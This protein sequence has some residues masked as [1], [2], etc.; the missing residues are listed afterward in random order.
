MQCFDFEHINL[1][2][3]KCIVESRKECDT[4]VQIGKYK[5]RVPVIPANM[6]CVINEE[7]AEK[8]AKNGYF[9]IMHRFDIDVVEFIR[10]MKQKNLYSSISIGVNDD[11]YELLNI[12]R[13][14]DLIPEFITIDIAHGHA[15]KMETM[16]T[17]IRSIPEFNNVFVIA[18]NVGTPDAVRD[19]EAWG[20]NGIKI[21]IAPGCFTGETRVLMSNG[22]YKN[23]KDITIGESVINKDGNPV[24]VLNVMNQG[25]KQVM[26]LK[27]NLHYTDTFVTKDHQFFIG[28]LS[29]S[30]TECISSSGIAKLLDKQAKTV[31][32]SSK[33]KWKKVG[34][35]DW[36]NT[37]TLFPKNINWNLSEN[38]TIDLNETLIRGECEEETITTNGGKE[39]VIF[40]RYLNSSYDLGYIFGTFL[41]NGSARIEINKVNNTECG[42]I[43]WSFADYK[44]DICEKLCK[45]IKTVLNIEIDYKLIKDKN[46]NAITLYNKCFT[47]ILFEFGKRINKHL[48]E[49]YF[50]KNKEYIQGIFDGL[51]DSDGHLEKNEK[52]I[53]NI[54]NFTNTSIQL[55]ELFEWCCFNLGI[56]FTSS[57]HN[58]T[59]P[60]G[61]LDNLSDN[62]VFNQGYR[63]KTHT[64]NRFTKNY[65]Y[66]SILDYDPSTK[67]EETWDIEVDCPTHSFIANNMIVHNSACTTYHSTGFGTRGIQLSS[68]HECSKATFKPET[69]II[70]DGGIKEAGDIAKCM[71]LG[72]NLT[73][74]GGMFSGMKD[75]PGNTVTLDGKSYKEY[76]GSASAF[77]SGKSNRIEGTKKLL[78][79][80]DKTILE[81]MVYI[82]ECLQSAISYGG[83][84][85]IKDMTNVDYII[86]K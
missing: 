59:N 17:W 23:I 4:S 46:I 62:P 11:A 66:S 49:K 5:F 84:K 42:S 48:P 60:Q 9:Y 41:G 82:E 21:G 7:I 79:L 45:C 38:F 61:G 30:S 73:M 68:V 10:S 2:P 8:L 72:A 26:R 77:Q 14:E 64:R 85:H 34:S 71:V 58:I 43:Y 6:E 52:Y 80:N 81:Q 39:P 56:S 40:N 55:I 1:V 33:Y 83:C 31:P 75:S 22:L 86:K 76:W 29:S 44:N 69:L 36:D 20:A 13:K 16:L 19:L 51:I 32:K 78:P 37:F 35:C 28:D 15:I 57:L 65:L 27:N 67:L 47:K 70:A 74:V 53:N 24:K 12:F 63:I 50:C 18:G 54:Y 3:R 25:F